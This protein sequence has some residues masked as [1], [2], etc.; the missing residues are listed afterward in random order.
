M[1]VLLLCALLCAHTVVAQS[2]DIADDSLPVSDYEAV[3]NVTKAILAGQVGMLAQAVRIPNSLFLKSPCQMVF[4]ASPD[5]ATY[6]IQVDFG[7]GGYSTSSS[8]GVTCT[9]RAFLAYIDGYNVP[10]G[11]TSV[12]KRN[13][14]PWASVLTDV[15][16]ALT[17]PSP[18]AAPE[19]PPPAYPPPPAAPEPAARRRR[20]QALALITSRLDVD[21]EV[22]A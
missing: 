18:S 22:G 1:L 8:T 17:G 21:V 14:V 10:K 2:P 6:E 15:T 20:R 16:K 3:S 4:L 12:T 5:W 19:A 11:V 7:S 13:A 9:R